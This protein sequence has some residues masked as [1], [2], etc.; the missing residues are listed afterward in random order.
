MKDS[1]L[2]R[3]SLVTVM[4]A[5]A[6]PARLPTASPQA[7]VAQ[8]RGDGRDL[9]VAGCDAVYKIQLKTPGPV[10]ADGRMQSVVR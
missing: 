9:Y 3:A 8:M 2:V 7:P 1:A 4:A 6:I 10:P 5:V